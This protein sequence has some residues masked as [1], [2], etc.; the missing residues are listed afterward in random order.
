MNYFKEADVVVVGG[1]IVGTAILRELS[2]YKLRALL[3]EKEHDVAMG[4][5]AANSAILHAGF[6]APTGSYKAR[7]N[8]RGNELF[9]ELEEDL[10][11]DIR[12]IGSLVVA[13][14]EEELA[15]VRELQARGE[16]NGVKGL[17]ILS[18]EEV[19]EKEPN[20]QNVVG[21]LWAPSAGVIWPFTA[22]VSFAEC[23]VQ[24]GAE[25]LRNT[26]CLGF[27][28]ENG[29]IAGVET[30]QGVI[31]T[32]YV[33]NAAG[34]YSDVIA[35]LAGDET[36]TISPRKGEY[37]LFEKSVSDRLV[38]GIVFPTP[39]KKSK[40]ILICTTTHGN[41]FIGPNANDQD[42][43]EDRSVTAQGMEEI[44]RSAQ[45]L[46]PNLPL[47]KTLTE[48]AGLRAVSSTGDFVLGKT[49]VPGFYNA[50][51]IQSP[52]LTSAPAIAEYVVEDLMREAKFEKKTDFRPALPR[53]KPFL[54]MTD[55]EKQE[56]IKKNKL[57]GRVVCRCE[58]VTEGEIVD[59]IHSLVGATTVDSVKRRCRAGMGPCQGSFC[60]PTV[61]LII[62]RELGIP[63]TEVV[64]GRGG[65]AL[66]YEKPRKK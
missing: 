55:E 17:K 48:F 6:D 20:L 9:H 36:F 62:A 61:A 26:E 52:G 16:A 37:I 7:L 1:G 53:R 44:I 27:I 51:G 34:V 46:I 13:T 39:T 45:K 3:I 8:V 64:K 66:Y 29:V 21:A 65:S 49:G 19:R 40:G 42:D 41:V 38:N 28:K 54:R 4:T 23:A 25:V 5:T 32:R 43:R 33:V 35:R 22:C 63:V 12:W 57:Y 59:A 14:N 15:S 10:N 47:H 58:T 2:K 24:N 56:L 11:L 30:R 60:G 31:K 18:A 50:A